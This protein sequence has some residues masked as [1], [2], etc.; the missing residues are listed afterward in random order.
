MRD[1][2]Q[3]DPPVF[4]SAAFLC[5]FCAFAF[6]CSLLL[7]TP[8]MATLSPAQVSFYLA[9]DIKSK[10]CIILGNAKKK[11]KKVINISHCE[12]GVVSLMSLFD[13]ALN[14]MVLTF[15]ADMC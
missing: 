14:G 7:V 3:S 1:L 15:P 12:R 5:T 4:L 11:K 9:I 2:L 10:L 6:R 13:D 8:R